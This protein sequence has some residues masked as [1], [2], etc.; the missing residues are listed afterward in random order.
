MARKARPRKTP[1]GEKPKHGS[2]LYIPEYAAQAR[3]LAALGWTHIEI[4]DFFDVSDRTFRRWMAKFPKLVEAMLIPEEEANK[5]VVLSLYQLAT[6]Y[7]RDEEEI[8]IIKGKVVRVKVKRY[9]PA[10]PSAAIFWA[11]AKV[12][13]T[14]NPALREPPT[15]L[16]DGAQAENQHETDK[17]IAR[18]IAFA[19]VQAT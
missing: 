14:D 7:E 8:K 13:L 5:R 4:A 11:K 18:R 1:A 10:N 9:Y 16:D 2:N 17:Q 15:P 19:I 6:G 12:G 3:K